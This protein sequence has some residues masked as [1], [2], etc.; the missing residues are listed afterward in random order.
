MRIGVR[1]ILGF[2]TIALLVGVIGY[3]SIDISKK[4]LQ[5]S[6]GERSVVL[7]QERVNRIDRNIYDKI[8]EFI[9]YSNSLMSQEA[10][11][12]SNKE[13][14]KFGNIQDYINEK[15][16]EWT[17]APKE[18]ITPL[19]QELIN[20]KLSEE[21]R[22]KTKFYEKRYGYRV[23]GEVFVT[24]RYGAN[25]AQTGK[26]TDYYQAD[27]E[28]WQ[29]AK[30][31]GLYVGDVEYDES[32]GIYSIPV[33]IRIN[34]EDGDFL[35]IT[36]AVL[37]IEYVISIVREIYAT[38][39]YKS[40]QFKLITRD[41]KIIYSTE[42]LKFL[43]DMPSE[44]S[45]LLKEKGEDTGYFTAKGDIPGEGDELFA[46]AHSKGYKDFKGLGWI[47]IVEYEIKGIFAPVTRFGYNILIIFLAAVVF[48]L[49]MGVFLSRSI[50]NPITR[51]KDM[52]DKI[53]KGNLAEP[54]EIKG[55]DEIS[56]LAE[57]FD[58]MRYSLK[59]VIDEYEKMKSREETIEEL[60]KS[61]E[62]LELS[63]IKYKTVFEGARDG[64]LAADAKT[65]KFLFANPQICRM[66]GYSEKELLGL[67]IKD[68][69][70]KKDLP[71]V[72][73][74]FNKQA[75]GEIDIARDIPALRKDKRVVYY[76]VNSTPIHIGKQS[77]VLGFFR[78]ISQEKKKIGQLERF[79]KL[80]I[81]REEK[82]IELKNRIKELE[83]QLKK[84]KR[85]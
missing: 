36:K 81:G 27:E 80:S 75:K 78:D 8:E 12:E 20:N 40:G 68:I 67:G 73:E 76:D 45:S 7:A 63:E 77:L 32:T 70:P 43:E 16:R 42:G 31:D 49:I 22:E 10:C 51:L 60:K 59:M 46:Y 15:D 84:R 64:I 14:E 66:L 56:E 52:A 1:L 85:G 44:I 18:E 48:A 41:K 2:L 34:D 72:I 28:W 25:I 54:I 82:M 69:H 71:Y 47:L 5:G 33:G 29:K 35:G 83:K 24:N 9:A 17:S 11:I 30:E 65:K 13:F 37:N 57:S 79:A 26:T 19:M 74:Q 53:S 6:I 55:K 58:N 23:F 3:I 4:A 61:K 62:E 21:L 38:R 39:T 50:S